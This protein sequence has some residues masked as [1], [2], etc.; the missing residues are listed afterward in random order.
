VANK[1]VIHIT[2]YPETLDNSYTVY[3][4]EGGRLLN[5]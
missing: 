3:R 2:H 1:T 5:E 4:M